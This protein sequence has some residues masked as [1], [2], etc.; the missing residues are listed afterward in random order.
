MRRPDALLAGLTAFILI[1]LAGCAAH[2]PASPPPGAD[3]LAELN[4]VMGALELMASLP[5]L[6]AAHQAQQLQAA[7]DA[8]DILPTTSNRLRYALAL[9]TPGHP[10]ADPVA[11]Q[12]QLSELLGASENLLT[13][14]R[15]LAQVQLQQVEQTLALKAENQRLRDA[16]PHDSGAK[17][18]A[19]TRRLAA[20][21]DDNARLRK[22]LDEA[23]SKLDAI[24]HLDRSINDHS[25]NPARP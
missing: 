24:S 3:T 8:A 16:T 14:E 7:K 22:E 6:D 10:G 9:A 2:K 21:S 11:A 12:R 25:A 4:P 1:S 23:R 15:R 18:A 5:R 20:E 17:L 13:V 19:V